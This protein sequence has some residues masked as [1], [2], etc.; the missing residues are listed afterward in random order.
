M[1]PAQAKAV[2]ELNVPGVYAQTEY[3]RYY[4]AGGVMA[5]IVGFTDID[6]KGQEE[7]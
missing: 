3:R 2:L 1:S 7:V 5:H 4:P 6:G